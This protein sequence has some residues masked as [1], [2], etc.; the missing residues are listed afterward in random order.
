MEKV[1]QKLLGFFSYSRKGI[2][3]KNPVEWHFTA[4]KYDNN[5][6]IHSMALNKSPWQIYTVQLD[7]PEASLL[8]IEYEQNDYIMYL[9]SFQE[10]GMPIEQYDELLNH[11]IRV[12]KVAVNFVQNIKI[13]SDETISLKGIIHYVISD[14]VSKLETHLKEFSLTLNDK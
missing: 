5:Y 4:K 3:N 10:V 14:G 8:S 9:G 7:F 13:I 6:K 2:Q 1:L 12:Y 11:N